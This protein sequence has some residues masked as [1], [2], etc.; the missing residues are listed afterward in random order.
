MIVEVPKKHPSESRSGAEDQNKAQQKSD[1][2]DG[3]DRMSHTEESSAAQYATPESLSS[4]STGLS[5]PPTSPSAPSP[6]QSNPYSSATMYGFSPQSPGFPH[7]PN[8]P[9]VG[10]FPAQWQQQ[11]RSQPSPCANQSTPGFSFAPSGPSSQAWA[12]CSGQGQSF[13]AAGQSMAAGSQPSNA[14]PYTSYGAFGL[15]DSGGAF[16]MDLSDLQ[17]VQAAPDSGGT[18]FAFPDCAFVDDT[19]T[20]W[21]TAPASFG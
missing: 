17:G 15:V 12:S 19:M 13:G 21:A 1:A 2:V 4:S 7:L 9:Q 20:M 16:P 5:S 6:G 3:G 18:D 10:S 14:A 11:P 8:D